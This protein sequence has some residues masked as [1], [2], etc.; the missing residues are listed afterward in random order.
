MVE[1]GK[2]WGVKAVQFLPRQKEFKRLRTADDFREPGGAS[3]A[4]HP[5]DP[6]LGKREDCCL[7][8][9]SNVAGERE[10]GARTAGHPGD[11]RD[12]RLRQMLEGTEGVLSAGRLLLCLLRGEFRPLLHVDSV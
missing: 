11:G 3:V 8:C 7:V 2:R 5:A 10:L 4:R 12:G 6:R 9:D 1:V